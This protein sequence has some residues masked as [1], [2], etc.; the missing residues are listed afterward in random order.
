VHLGLVSPPSR[1][2]D[3]VLRRA[4]EAG[5]RQRVH[6]LPYVAADDVPAYLSTAD[7]GVIPLL[8]SPNHDVAMST[9]W[10]DYAH[11]RLP[12]VVSDVASMAAECR[13]LGNGEVFPP[14]DVQGCAAAVRAV[15]ADP[16]AYRRAYTPVV[17]RTGTWQ[18]QSTELLALY[19]RISG[20]QPRQPATRSAFGLLP[21]DR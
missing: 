14:A 19:T 1:F 12:V 3:D 5:V 8:P 15:L 9:K 4:D 13:R 6:V 16:G 17:L 21:M 2:L 10:Y 11:A 20:Q 18:H 7:A